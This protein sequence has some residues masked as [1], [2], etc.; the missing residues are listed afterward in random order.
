MSLATERALSLFGARAQPKQTR[1][2][3]YTTLVDPDFADGVQMYQADD[4]AFSGLSE[5]DSYAQEQVHRERSS[6]DRGAIGRNCTADHGCRIRA[7]ADCWSSIT[8]LD[9]KRGVW[10]VDA[11]DAD[12]DLGT[13]HEEDIPRV[14]GR[15]RQLR[16]RAR[17][18]IASALERARDGWESF[19][20][21]LSQVKRRGG[22]VPGPCFY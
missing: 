2:F 16:R 22:V 1:E 15:A 14:E 18:K 8:A 4:L 13:I 10:G 17:R 5:P 20:L 9:I 7:S 21:S 11:L 3:S 19:L 6:E 12:T